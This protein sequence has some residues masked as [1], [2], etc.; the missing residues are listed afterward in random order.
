MNRAT[1]L[2]EDGTQFSGEPLGK[3]GVAIGPLFFDTRVVGYQEIITDPANAGKILLFTYPL[4]GNYGINPK[5]NES[6]RAQVKGVV[7]K[8]KSKIYSNWQAK[9]SW[10]DFL[11]QE[12]LV[13]ITEVDTRTL[14]VYL[15]EKGEI[16]AAIS[17]N[18]KSTEELLAEIKRLKQKTMPNW[19]K[20]ISTPQIQTIKG[21]SKLRIGIL[22]LGVLQSLISQL[23]NLGL[24]ILILPYQSSG[25]DILKLKLKGLIISSGPEEDWVLDEIIST[26]KKLIGKIPILGIALGSQLLAKALGAKIKKMHLGHH[27]VNYPLKYSSSHKGDITV[28]NHSWVIDSDS[29][30]KIKHIRI[31]ALHLNDA[32][33][34]GFA[35]K[36]YKLMAIQYYPISPGFEEV[37]S[38]LTKFL[39]L[40]N[41]ALPKIKDK[42]KIKKGRAG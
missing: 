25:D 41:P 30:K 11:V 1:L 18:G 15:R 5:F 17:T 34:E 31:T 33:V 39:K 7:I 36:K 23:K 24:Q 32:T 14:A 2:L 12:K 16:W 9:G 6:G 40:M 37:N 38:V 10:D 4:I 26:L 28:Q 27:G 22:D 20:E 13:G 29:L 35:S 3:K 42:R 8:E 21:K 19:I